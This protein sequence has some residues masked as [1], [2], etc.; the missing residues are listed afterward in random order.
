MIDDYESLSCLPLE[1]KSGRSYSIHSAL[2][3]LVSNDTYNVK[4][5]YVLSNERT[6]SIKGKIIYIP[7]YYAMFFS[8][9]D[10]D[11]LIK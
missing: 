3:N 2:N 9:N 4:K 7:I 10:G 11:L 6:I 5:A 1:V 8:Q